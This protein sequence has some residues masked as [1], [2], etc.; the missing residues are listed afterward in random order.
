MPTLGRLTMSLPQIRY[1]VAVAKSGSFTAAARLLHVSQPALTVRIKQLE[2]RLG[3]Q[4]LIRHA[5]GVELTEAGNAFLAHANEALEALDRAERAVAG[6]K[7]TASE[8]VSLGVTP[9]PGRALVADLLKECSRKK[10]PLRILLREGL[11]DE[12]WQLVTGAELDAAFCYDPVAAD[13]TKIIPLYREDLFLVGPPN[14]VD[15]AQGEVDLATLGGLPLVLG[16]RDHR[17]RRFIET[18]AEERGVDLQSALEVEPITLKR[19]MLMRHGCCSIVP[20]GLFWD[21]I[22]AGHLG[23]RR[24]HPPIRRTVALVVNKGIKPSAERFLV[25]TIRSIV[26]R[27]V[28]EGELGWRKS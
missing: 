27:L 12:L 25:T 1:F 16:Y 14:V 10:P 26:E 9:T 19:E 28:Q 2:E 4:L 22:K 21:W 6:F 11:T 20:Y 18:V 13:T 5:R 7:K 3:S 15:T 23:A 24:I 8:E 17:T